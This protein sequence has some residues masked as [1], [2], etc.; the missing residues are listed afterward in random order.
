MAGWN[1]LWPSHARPSRPCL[2]PEEENRPGHGR[3][4]LP[5]RREAPSPLRRAVRPP[6][7]TRGRVAEICAQL[8]FGVVFCRCFCYGWVL[9]P[10]GVRTFPRRGGGGRRVG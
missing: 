3:R 1:G 10:H 6:L 5:R 7:T 2:T 4:M 9:C 8:L